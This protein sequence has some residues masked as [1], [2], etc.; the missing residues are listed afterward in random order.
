MIASDPFVKKDSVLILKGKFPLYLFEIV[1]PTDD[2][3]CMKVEYKNVIYHVRVKH[4][5]DKMGTP[6]KSYLW[7]MLDWYARSKARPTL[8][9]IN[10]N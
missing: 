4:D 9:E 2:P 5:L 10:A 6:P 1:P 8:R 3:D 7:E